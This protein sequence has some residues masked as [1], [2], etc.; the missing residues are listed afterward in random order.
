VFSARW[1][2]VAACLAA[3]AGFFSLAAIASA[4]EPSQAPSPPPAAAVGHASP[5]R[6]RGGWYL[7]DPYQY[8][9]YRRGVPVLS[10]FDVETER[11]LARILGV[12]LQLAEIAW[13]DHQAALQ[14]GT[15]DIAAGATETEA[16][17]AYALFSKPYR[18]E[19]DV[20]VVR[21]GMAR[22]Y[23]F[24]SIDAMLSAF[25]RQKF[26]LGVVAGFVYA[27]PRV[28]AFIA[29]PANKELI[30]ASG[31]VE[32]NLRNLMSGAIDGFLADRIAAATAAWRR[33]QGALIE[34]HPLRFS[35]DIHFMLSR[36]T[37]TPQMLARV[38]A[39]IDQLRES[40]ELRRLA[41]FYALP[42][43][44]STGRA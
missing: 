12:E 30:V 8:R 40:G 31:G 28:N 14:K 21:K 41:A 4:Q 29:D 25:A 3:I 22:R 32:Q 26:R 13:S 2:K 23:P 16:R 18:S 1:R 5:D 19:T 43:L 27:D 17:R 36:A 6:L 37:Q 38:D 11:A 33:Q 10:G 7:W 15:A 34:E 39:A 35:T 44:R 42:V 24:A 20:L 9:D